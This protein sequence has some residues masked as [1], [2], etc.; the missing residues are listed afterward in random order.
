M[1]IIT[2]LGKTNVGKSTLFNNILKKKQSIISKKKNT[3]T[4]CIINTKYD[5]KT[6]KILIDTPGPIIRHHK[7]IYNT[8]TFIFDTIIKAHIFIIIIDTLNLT[9]ED[10]FILDII[11]K[12]KKIKFLL[13]N[14]IDKIKDKTQLL[15]F[16][17][18]MKH[19]LNFDHIIPI[20][21]IQ[22]TNINTFKKILNQYNFKNAKENIYSQESKQNLTKELIR[23]T[24]LNKLNKELPY[25]TQIKINNIKL[26]NKTKYLS[27]EIIT[28][29]IN[30]KK[31]IIGKKGQKI[32]QITKEIN[33]KIKLIHTNIKDIKTIVNYTKHGKK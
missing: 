27:I 23:E 18:K 25:K 11:K 21:N 2:I 1:T 33:K 8:N 16:I 30:Q 3:T 19:F 6:I 10:F 28:Q 26:N 31:I 15:P 17:K 9:T 7:Q 32:K 29:N 13:I 14:K 24:L 4:R 22:H 5:N 12:H 20:S